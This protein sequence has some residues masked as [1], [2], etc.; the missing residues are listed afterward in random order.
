[1]PRRSSSID[2]LSSPYWERDFPVA[3]E[4]ETLVA[5]E[6]ASGLELIT[7]CLLYFSQVLGVIAEGNVRGA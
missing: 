4:R 5:L 6:M 7:K 2:S 1:M 3:G